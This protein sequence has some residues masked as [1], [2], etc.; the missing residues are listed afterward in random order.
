[1]R[2]GGGKSKGSGFEREVAKKIVKAFSKF[3]IKETDCYRTPLSGGHRVASKADPGDLVISPE[4]RELFP[5]T[6]E[7]KRVEAFSLVHLLVPSAVREKKKSWLENKFLDQAVR[8]TLPKTRPLLVVRRNNEEPLALFESVPMLEGLPCLRFE[9]RSTMKR[10]PRP[11]SC[12]G[13]DDFLRR[14]VD[15]ARADRADWGV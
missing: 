14:C 10:P 15:A 13:L 2:P 8:E 7:C 6:V 12:T 4:L 3:G 5:F 11:W 9:R 1:M